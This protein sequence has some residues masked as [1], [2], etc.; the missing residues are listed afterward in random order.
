MFQLD[1]ELPMLFCSKADP[2]AVQTADAG[3]IR[4]G[5]GLRLPAATAD[6]DAIRL[7]GGFRLPAATADAGKIRLGGGFR[8]P[9]VSA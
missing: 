3:K 1:R 5:G 4:P 7:G 8:L 6:A 2:A 9:V